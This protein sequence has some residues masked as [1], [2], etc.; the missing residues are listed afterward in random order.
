ML[1]QRA[2]SILKIKSQKKVMHIKRKVKSNYGSPSGTQ[3]TDISIL[4]LKI[5]KSKFIMMMELKD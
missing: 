3:E 1:K 5:I 4:D 2:L